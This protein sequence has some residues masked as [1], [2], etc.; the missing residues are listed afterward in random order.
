M[1]T[2]CNWLHLEILGLITPKYLPGRCHNVYEYGRR[3]GPHCP[4]GYIDAIHVY[5]MGC[6]ELGRVTVQSYA[7]K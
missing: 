2:T 3:N 1:I 4:L 7:M 5:C 6:P